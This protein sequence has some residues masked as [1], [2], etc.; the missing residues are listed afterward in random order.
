MDS[1]DQNIIGHG[2]SCWN[3]MLLKLVNLIYAHLHFFLRSIVDKFGNTY[4]SEEIKYSLIES[5]EIFTINQ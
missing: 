5:H 2:T 1:Q 4:S 3:T